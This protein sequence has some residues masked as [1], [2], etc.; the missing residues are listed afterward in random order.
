MGIDLRGGVKLIY[1]L[2]QSKLQSGNVDELI[3]PSSPTRPTKSAA[4]PRRKADVVPL[5]DQKLQV[6]LP[7]VDPKTIDEIKTGIGKLKVGNDASPLTLAE[8]QTQDGGTLLT[9]TVKTA[10][11]DVKMDDIV[12]AVSKRVNP[13]GQREVAIRTVGSN[14]IEVAIPNVDP[15]EIDYI[16]KK[17]ATAGAWNSASWPIAARRTISAPSMLPSAKLIIPRTT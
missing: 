12:K 5:S 6:K 2:D 11:R 17:I 10:K 15:S 9:Y 1:E 8:Q 16:K 7:T 3:R 14:Q 13:G 4:L